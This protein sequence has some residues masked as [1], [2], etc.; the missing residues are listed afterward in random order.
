MRGNHICLRVPL[1]HFRGWGRSRAYSYAPFTLQAFV[2]WLEVFLSSRTASQ[3]AP[4]CPSCSHY[5]W[6]TTDWTWCFNSRMTVLKMLVTLKLP[7]LT[8]TH[9]WRNVQ[10]VNSPY[11]TVLHQKMTESQTYVHCG[12]H[13]RLS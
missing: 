12:P 10:Y 8:L 2:P 6:M 7:P 9:L 1:P 5:K 11:V 3:V 4:F 13:L